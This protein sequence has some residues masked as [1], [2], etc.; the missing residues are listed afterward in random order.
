MRHFH[1]LIGDKRGSRTHA[2]TCTDHETDVCP[3]SGASTHVS[4]PPARY[5]LTLEILEARE[6]FSVNPII[7]EN[8]L[9]G[10]SS[11]VWGV[12]G[13]GDSTIQGFTTDISVNHGQTV[14]F[15]INDS[16][17]KLYHIDIYRTGYYQGNGARLVTTIPA[18][19]VLRQVQPHP[20][21]DTATGL[22]DAGNWAVSA[23]W[24]VPAA[25][26]SGLYFARVARDDTGGASL[27]WFVVRADGGASDLLFQTSDTTWEA[28]NQ[29]GGNSLYLG[30]APT[31]DGRAYKVSYNRP[32]VLDGIPGGYGDYNS[33]LHAEYPMIRWLE[34]NG[35]NVSYSTDVD[36]DRRGAELLGHKV[37]MSVGHD[38]YWSGPQRAN[39][40][41]ARDAGVNLA[42][43]SGNE[44]FWKTR[45]ETSIDGSGTS[46]RTLVTYKE[47]KDGARTDPL[48]ISQNIWTGTWRDTRFS[49]PADGGRPENAMSGTIYMNDRTSTDLGIPLQVSAAD[50]KLWF[51]RNTAVATLAA[52]Q[53]ATLG[54]FVVGYEVDEDLDNGFR[55]AGLIDMSSTTFSTPSHV[56]TPWGTDVGAGT[57]T[58]KLTLYRAASGALVFGAGTVQWSWGLDGNHNAQAST[59]DASM[60]QATVNLFADMG[61]QPGSLQTGLVAAAASTDFT[62]PTSTITAPAAGSAFQVGT[63]VTISGTATDAGGGQVGGVEVSVDGGATWHPA[64]GRGTWS[65]T[66]VP[67]GSG[68][69]VI[70][71]RATDDR[72]NIEVPGPG[73]SVTVARGNSTSLWT[74]TTT[75]ATPSANDPNPVEV[76]VKFRSSL[77]GN[78]TGLRFYKGA[79]NTGTH[80]GKLWSSTGTLLASATFTGE[81]ASGWQAVTFSTPVAIA[82][83]TTYVASYYAPTGG[84]AFNGGYFASAGVDSAPLRALANG[85]DGPNGVY[86]YGAG[87]G[88]PTNSY[89]STNYWVDVVFT[90]GASDTTPPTVVGVTPANNSTGVLPNTPITVTFS[91]AVDPTTITLVVKDASNAVVPGTL[92]YDP[93][94]FVA[95][96]TP[97]APLP[98]AATYTATVSG[99]KDL[100]GNSLAAAVTWSFK[101]RGIWL[102]TSVADFTTGTTAGTVVT[103]DSGGEVTLAPL[104]HE[105]FN[106]TTLSATTWATNSWAAG[107]TLTVSNGILT[108]GRSGVLST[109]GFTNTALEGRV[110]FGASAYQHFGW[111]TGFASTAGNYWAV[112]ST[113]GTTNQLY[114]RVNANGSTTDVAIGTLPTGYHTYKIVPVS[115]GFEFYMDGTLR[116]TIAASFQS[117]VALKAGLSDYLGTSGQLLQADWITVKTYSTTQTGL[118]TSAVYAAPG[119]VTWDAM[120]ITTTVPTGT[121][122]SVSVK[123]GTQTTGGM[124]WQAAV[125]GADGKIRDQ[126]NNPIVGQYIQY[127]ATFTT[128]DPTKTPILDDIG[129]TWL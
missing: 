76:G 58:H 89:Q 25:A 46:Y 65:Y 39:V 116:T 127:T 22:V 42:F 55:P 53:T 68:T 84:Y 36:T 108:V 30:T 23:T 81:T 56:L 120:I 123:I 98:P 15:K 93:T 63:A 75:P 1:W 64:T 62:P 126:S 71:S 18:A 49:P 7:A 19:R 109:Q 24:A 113:Y 4:A 14:S 45:W 77:A 33:P 121:S 107:G 6:V 20:L 67:T 38:E 54:Q 82:A 96:F 117:R 114:A 102:Q 122:L 95:S 26:T 61:A 28:Y 21:T 12:S 115:T 8:Q 90:Q 50:G 94:A 13:S 48:D 100:S 11:D 51:W 32:L 97:A 110:Q 125:V 5:R 27:I 85:E 119:P 91:E 124:V 112:F 99:A 66:W 2:S 70:K 9:P 16:A 128:S 118:Y 101:T 104:F 41:A 47:S 44:G 37:F 69:V 73:V 72:G 10:T 59:P 74:S 3:G 87:G 83:N 57:G 35:Y 103:N 105:D 17:N 92:T 88:F 79:G 52:G 40:E 78:I 106:G 29:W 80:V 60:Q 31:P 86:R 43:F 111:A 34:A 129:F